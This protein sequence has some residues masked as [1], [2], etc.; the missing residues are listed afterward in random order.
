ME[1]H[2]RISSPHQSPHQSPRQRAAAASAAAAVGVSPVR[3]VYMSGGTEGA[4]AIP[5]EIRCRACPWQI[6]TY[7]LACILPQ[8]RMHVCLRM[9]SMRSTVDYSSCFVSIRKETKEGRNTHKHCIGFSPR[10][11]LWSIPWRAVVC[12]TGG[13]GE[14]RLLLLYG[15]RGEPHGVSRQSP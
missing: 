12:T 10:Y 8:S 5:A 7:R 11:K 3:F 2:G 13:H 15:C 6:L 4:T 9:Y 1:E 14:P